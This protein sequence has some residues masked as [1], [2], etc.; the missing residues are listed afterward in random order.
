MGRE[1]AALTR[2]EDIVLA[3]NDHHREYHDL[4]VKKQPWREIFLENLRVK[5]LRLYFKEREKENK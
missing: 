1:E 2:K 3:H 5:N 4:P